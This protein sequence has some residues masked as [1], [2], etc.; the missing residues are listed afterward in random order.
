MEKKLISLIMAGG[1]GARFWPLSRENCPK[2]FLNIG[3]K[4]SLLARTYRRAGLVSQTVPP[5][6]AAG[7]DQ[8]PLVL[9][10]CGT[11]ISRDQ[12]VT[13]PL[14]RNTAAAIYWSCFKIAQR[15]DDGIIAVF[16]AD[17]QIGDDDLFVETIDRAAAAAL[18]SGGVV[19][20]GIRPKY[21]ATGYGYV[22]RG[23]KVEEDGLSY[24]KVRRFVEKPHRE[25]AR[26][27]LKK[28]TYNWN[29]G[30]FVF[31]LKRIFEIYQEYLPEFVK[32]FSPMI[33]A[34]NTDDEQE[35]LRH[36]F[37]ELPSISFDVGILEKCK[38]IAMV[39]THFS[40]DDVGSYNSLGALLDDDENA[41]IKSGNI[42]ARDVKNSVIIADNHL[43]TVLGLRDVVVVEDHGVLLICPRKR[44]EEIKDLVSSL[45]GNN[46]DY[47]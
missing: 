10:H 39:E 44:V 22:E 18:H 17:H 34:I 15:H 5:Y 6:I 20:I 2:Q 16:P 37:T 46:L 8:V 24:Y 29:S 41:N 35:T 27:Y 19:V 1:K 14:P 26:R 4:D 30:I 9:C 36:I 47:R 38:N 13:E 43:V 25:K 28:G 42:I 7:E 32:A 31:S 3:G 12:I 45:D 11:E 21:I 23:K 40:W 33:D